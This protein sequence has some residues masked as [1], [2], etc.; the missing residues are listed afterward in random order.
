MS[1]RRLIELFDS[2]VG[3]TPKLYLRVARFQHAKQ[4]LE[5]PATRSVELAA[6]C[7]YFDQSHL[8]RDF[9]AFSG[10]TPSAYRMQA[11]ARQ[12]KENHVALA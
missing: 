5:S 9:L 4:C 7:G 2:E 1:H 8:I 11:D 10:L 12:V 6:E 3:M